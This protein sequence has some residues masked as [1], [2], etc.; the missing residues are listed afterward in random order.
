MDFSA[1][2][3]VKF[4]IASFYPL[5]VGG[6]TKPHSHFKHSSIT[7][8]FDNDTVDLWTGFA[9]AY[10]YAAANSYWGVNI[11]ALNSSGFKSAVT[12]YK[13]LLEA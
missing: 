13:F 5:T 4:L 9:K 3:D 11:Y 12:S 8:D 1:G 10:P 2:V 6:K 7:V